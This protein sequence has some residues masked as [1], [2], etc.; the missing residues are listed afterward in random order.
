MEQKYV[1]ATIQTWEG[2]EVNWSLI[3]Q[4]KINEE[5]QMRKA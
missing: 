2:H 4:Q 1:V 5:I 3:V